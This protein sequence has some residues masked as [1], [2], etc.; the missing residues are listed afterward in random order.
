MTELKVARNAEDLAAYQ[1]HAKEVIVFAESN[2]YRYIKVN[3][4]QA[5]QLRGAGVNF[6][7]DT[8][9]NEVNAIRIPPTQIAKAEQILNSNSAK[10]GI[11]K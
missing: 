5:E 4:E 6:E 9:I 11:K 10:N 7:G 2:Q 8:S 1:E 3:R